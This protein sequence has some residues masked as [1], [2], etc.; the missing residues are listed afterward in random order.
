V[1]VNTDESLHDGL[2]SLLKDHEACGVKLQF[3][4]PCGGDPLRDGA[5][6]LQ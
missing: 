4:L 3:Y 6:S 1:A 2:T 5:R